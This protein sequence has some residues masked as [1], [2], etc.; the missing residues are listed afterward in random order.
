[1]RRTYFFGVAT[2]T[3]DREGAVTATGDSTGLNEADISSVLDQFRG[4][5]D[6]YVSLYSSVKVD[7][8]KLRVLMR[9]ERYAKSVSFDDEMHKHLILTPVEGSNAPALDIPVP[10]R[11][12]SIYDIS[13]ISCRTAAGNELAELQLPENAPEQFTV[14]RIRVHC[15]KGTYVRQLAEDI[16]DALGTPATLLQ[17][18]RTSI[19]DVSIADT[20][21]IESLS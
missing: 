5:I 2:D 4:E 11:R 14:A 6:Q 20:V 8:K 19:A 10:R 21:D 9:D 15:S 16:G 17:L 1:M 3:Q 18:T 13:L 12:I 7:G